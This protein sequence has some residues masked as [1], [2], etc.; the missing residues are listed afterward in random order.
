MKRSLPDFRSLPDLLLRHGEKAG[1]A[2]ALVGAALLAWG[3]IDALRS[4]SVTDALAPEAVDRAAAQARGHIDREAQAPG[5]LLTPREPLANAIDPWRT[6]LVPW[7]SGSSPSLAIADPPA[8]AVLDSPLFAEVAKRGK[9]DVL[10]MEDLRA[11]AG[12]AVVPAAAP[13]GAGPRPA[14]PPDRPKRP[15]RRPPR[16]GDPLAGPDAPEAAAA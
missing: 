10:P 8:V 15:D 11:T 4:L 9:P 3:G 14:A 5:D 7:Q 13:P 2:V 1:L 12:L 6:P 16:G